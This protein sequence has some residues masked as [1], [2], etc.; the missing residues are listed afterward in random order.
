[1]LNTVL[2]IEVNNNVFYFSLIVAVCVTL[3]EIVMI[4]AYDKIDKD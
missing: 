3:W 1:M 4:K 2:I